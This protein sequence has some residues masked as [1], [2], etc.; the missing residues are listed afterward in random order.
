[1]RSFAVSGKKDDVQRRFDA[2]YQA[3]HARISSYALH[4]ASTEDAADVVAE[5]F[6][7]AW[8]RLADVPTGEEARLWLYGTAR[9]VLANQRRSEQRRSNLRIRLGLERPPQPQELFEREGVDRTWQALTRLP[10]R[11]RDLLG[12]IAW[13]GLGLPELAKVLG[14]SENAAKLRVHRA[15]HRLRSQIARERGPGAPLRVMEAP[16]PS[17]EITRLIQQ[18]PRQQKQ[19]SRLVRLTLGIVE[20]VIMAA[21]AI[22]FLSGQLRFVSKDS[23]K[24]R[25]SLTAA[26]V[27]LQGGHCLMGGE[28]SA[29]SDEIPETFTGG[30]TSRSTTPLRRQP[31]GVV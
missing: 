19:R 27:A 29:I 1:M 15:K 3:N 23:A 18:V 12:L 26:G 7:I 31:V 17:P 8:R 28:D 20:M 16:I 13:E 5:T 6:L 9:R 11:Q 21:I 14:C 10:V 2:L 24:V 22:A 25:K 30:A 4:R